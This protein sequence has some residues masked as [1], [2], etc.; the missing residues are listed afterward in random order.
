MIVSNTYSYYV[1]LNIGSRRYNYIITLEFGFVNRISEDRQ[2]LHGSE[3][4]RLTL[5]RHN[6]TTGNVSRKRRGKSHLVITPKKA[7]ATTVR[8]LGDKPNLKA[9]LLSVLDILFNQGE[10]DWAEQTE[11]EVRRVVLD[12][13][14]RE[15]TL[16]AVNHEL[17]TFVEGILNG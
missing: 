10:V 13:A 6:L 11:R 12:V 17:E 2:A 16:D 14:L 1:P 3:T 8:S 7:V 5:E 4:T 15:I 9:G